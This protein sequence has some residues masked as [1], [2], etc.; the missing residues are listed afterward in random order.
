MQTPTGREG[1]TVDGERI[2]ASPFGRAVRTRAVG[3]GVN[4]LRFTALLPD[5]D[6]VATGP[7]AVVLDG[8]SGA[9]GGGVALAAAA[10]PLVW[11]SP[12]RKPC[13]L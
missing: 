5:R 11:R 8:R 13:V 1:V 9:V 10:A 4:A 6:E 3:R 7:N 2:S 12:T